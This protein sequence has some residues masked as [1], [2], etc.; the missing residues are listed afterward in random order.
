MS[1]AAV[2]PAPIEHQRSLWP[3]QWSLLVLPALVL[4]IVFLA[5]PYLN[6]VVMSFRNPSTSAPYAPGFTLLN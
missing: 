2:L 3:S 4:V 1:V 6:I 5:V